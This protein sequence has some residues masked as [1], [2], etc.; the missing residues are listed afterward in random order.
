MIKG[1]NIMF[2][3]FVKRIAESKNREDALRNVFYGADGIDVA[4]QREKISWA[5]HELLL[6]I[7]D[8]MA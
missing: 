4:F 3:R 7:I 1:V 8:K 2:K 5:E 6:A